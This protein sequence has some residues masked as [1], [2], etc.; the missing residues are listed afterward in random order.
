MDI[1]LIGAPLSPFVRKARFVFHAKNIGYEFDP[2][3]SPLHV[4]E[5]YVKLNPL[6]LIP[7]MTVTENGT[8]TAIPDSSAICAFAEKIAP[9]PSLYPAAPVAFAR[10]LWFEEYADTEIAKKGTFTFF[11]TVFF[12]LVAG[13]EPQYEELH[14]G[15]DYL[16][17]IAS[18]IDSQLGDNDWL[19]GNE[20]SLADV[21]VA[22]HF[23]NIHH[24]GYDFQEADGAA[25]YGLIQRVFAH[26][27]M[28]DIIA[29][30]H[31][32]LAKMGYEKPD[33]NAYRAENNL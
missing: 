1:K 19:V 20:M 18:Y 17:E 2:R 25:L 22:S 6:K 9:E 24:A 14:I 27:V 10:C 21:S 33:L 3:V 29:G 12:A 28:A 4:P 23:V 31:K 7:A 30:E 16:A 8:Q 15:F 26:P 5:E 13:K 11:R 32:L